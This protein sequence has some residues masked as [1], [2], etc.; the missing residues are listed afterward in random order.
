VV[1]NDG[2]TIYIPRAAHV[3]VFGQVKNPGS[4]PI[5]AGTT[6]LQ[7]LALAGGVTPYAATNR[8]QVIRA[9]NGRKQ[10]LRIKLV[11]LVQPGDTIVVPE[12][13]F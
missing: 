4:Y 11:D 5:H 2:D 3:Y 6:A 8:V 10:E 13:F 12:R 9:V 1:L 7:A